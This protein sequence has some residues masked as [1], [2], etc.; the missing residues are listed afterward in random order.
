MSVVKF[1]KISI[2]YNATDKQSYDH[3]VNS[4]IATFCYNETYCYRGLDDSVTYD[5]KQNISQSSGQGPEFYGNKCRNLQ[6]EGWLVGS[7]SFKSLEL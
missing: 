3:S 7:G 6:K 4:S 2:I 1:S 5:Y